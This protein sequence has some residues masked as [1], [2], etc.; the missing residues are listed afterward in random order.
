MVL[1][2]PTLQQQ[3]LEV[4]L[5]VGRRTVKEHQ[6]VG[7]VEVDEVVAEVAGEGVGG[8]APPRAATQP[9]FRRLQQRWF[10]RQPVHRF[11]LYRWSRGWSCAVHT[12]WWQLSYHPHSLD[13]ENLQRR[14]Q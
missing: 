1:G 5:A 4:V 3:D 7:A 8:E 6:R 11:D 9:W 12:G 10:S 13:K 2:Q 14:L